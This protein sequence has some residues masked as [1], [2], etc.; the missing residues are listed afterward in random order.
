MAFNTTKEMALDLIVMTL[1]SN[2]PKD[3][4]NLSQNAIVKIEDT[5]RIGGERAEYA[6]YTEENNQSSKGWIKSTIEMLQPTLQSFFENN[7]SNKDIN[8]MTQSQEL[9]FN[10]QFDYM[11]DLRDKKER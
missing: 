11:A 10:K 2:A 5:V 4:G 9:S 7:L 6:Q 8:E 1:K 3:T